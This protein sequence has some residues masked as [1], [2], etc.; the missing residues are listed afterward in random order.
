MLGVDV[1]KSTDHW[2]VSQWGSRISTGRCLAPRKTFPHLYQH[3]ARARERRRNL[4]TLVD[5]FVSG[6]PIASISRTHAQHP[7]HHAVNALKHWQRGT[8]AKPRYRIE[9]WVGTVGTAQNE[10][11]ASLQNTRYQTK[12]S[13]KRRIHDTCA[14]LESCRYPREYPS[15]MPTLR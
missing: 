7:S 10:M 9:V 13:Q 11:P 12:H 6:G 1:D 4:A 5:V 14:H 2:P 15:L 8:R 3:L